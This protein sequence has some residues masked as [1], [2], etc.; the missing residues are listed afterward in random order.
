VVPTLWRL[1]V[2]NAFQS[3]NLTSIKYVYRR[4]FRKRRITPDG[5]IAF[6]GA[7]QSNSGEAAVSNRELQRHSSD[8]GA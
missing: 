1:E 6:I 8:L 5:P 2:A 3:A 7:H 4:I